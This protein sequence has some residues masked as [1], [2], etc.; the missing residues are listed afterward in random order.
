MQFKIFYAG[1][2]LKVISELLKL[3]SRM[4]FQDFPIKHIFKIKNFTITH[5]EK[6][7]LCFQAAEFQIVLTLFHSNI[8][9]N[10]ILLFTHKSWTISKIFLCNKKH[11]DNENGIAFRV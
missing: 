6:V 11:L 2:I 4:P 9:N 5:N 10:Y 1:Y 3:V 7:T 8:R